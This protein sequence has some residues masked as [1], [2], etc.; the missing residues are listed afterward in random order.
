VQRAADGEVDVA[1]QHL[2]AESKAV[3]LGARLCER[4]PHVASLHVSE[5]GAV[6][7]AHVGPGFLGVV[8]SR[9]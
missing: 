8:V 4:L 2:A 3:E 9:R 5:V 6:V 7:G 1:V